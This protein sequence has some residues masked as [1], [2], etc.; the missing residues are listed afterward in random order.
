MPFTNYTTEQLIDFVEDGNQIGHQDAVDELR[1]RL[2][3]E[4]DADDS[5]QHRGGIRPT[6]QPI[7]P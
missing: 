6:H 3:K 2:I 4:N 1:A 5:P 7:N